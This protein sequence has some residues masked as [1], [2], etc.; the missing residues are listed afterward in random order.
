MTLVAAALVASP[1]WARP[2]GAAPAGYTS[3]SASS[4]SATVTAAFSSPLRCSSV[5]KGDFRATVDGT[6]RTIGSVAC[7][8]PSDATIGI[9]LSG[10]PPTGGDEVAVTLVG[11][12]V[13]RGGT[14]LP[15]PVTHT[16]TVNTIE[17]DP[18]LAVTAGPAEG[19]VSSSAQPV[20]RGTATDPGGALARVEVSVD[21]AAF[22]TVGVT[23]PA[24]GTPSASWSFKPPVL[25]DGLHNLVWRSVDDA[26]NL[27]PVV[28][29]T[30]TV[31]TSLP[32][33]VSVESAGDGA[34]T[35]LFSKPVKCRGAKVDDFRATV[36][37]AARTVT[38]VACTGTAD[39]TLDLSLAGTLLPYDVI[40]VS[41]VGIVRDPTHQEAPYPTTRT[42]VVAI[43]IG[44]IQ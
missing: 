3:V 31:D 26:G 35:A 18:T 19:S 13:D 11:G 43:S 10:S 12:V 22:D 36:N 37:D 40:A 21:A 27:S 23:C 15:T 1:M 30:V 16:V 44:R 4:G 24:C 32:A 34:V 38:A 20:Y 14:R 33:F 25:S 42:T 2:V 17:A 28:E 5:A 9:A 8:Q 29:R 7:S 41:L 6:A 39:E